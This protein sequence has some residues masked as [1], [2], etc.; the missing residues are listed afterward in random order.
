MDALTETNIA[1]T[2]LVDRAAATPQDTEQR[3]WL[4][5]REYVVE[6]EI[7]AFA[8]ERGVTQPLRFDVVVELAE[9]GGQAGDDVDRV[10]SYDLLV[11]AVDAALA[12]AR[13]SLLETLAEDIAARLLTDPR[14]GRVF[15]KIEKLGRGPGALGIEILRRRGQGAVPVAPGTL[16]SPLV[17]F[18]SNA[19][20]AAPALTRWLER[21][22]AQPLP[23]ILC[24]GPCCDGG[25]PEG[26]TPEARAQIQHLSVD[27]NAWALAARDP[28]LS[29]VD[30]RTELDHAMRTGQIAVWAPSRLARAG[31][32]SGLPETL[33]SG[34]PLALWFA[35]EIGAERVVAIGAVPPLEAPVRVEY[36]SIA[37]AAEAL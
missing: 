21:L 22:E 27:Q 13:V 24:V 18:L 37:Q 1:F 28:R 29:V 36:L 15:I 26:A 2:D 23:V 19:A 34:L 33:G 17:L 5:L 9:S 25:Q 32:A 31:G 7:G 20:I 8:E 11:Q 4:S 30:S 35:A 14:A 12:G 16:P 10:M 6:A 3:D